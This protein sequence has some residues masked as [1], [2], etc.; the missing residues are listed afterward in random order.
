LGFPRLTIDGAVAVPGEPKPSEVAPIA[1]AFQ[2]RVPEKA[3]NRRGSAPIDDYFL[4]S[5]PAPS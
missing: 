3:A 1:L 4:A 5:A 2:A